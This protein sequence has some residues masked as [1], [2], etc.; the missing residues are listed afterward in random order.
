M[1]ITGL[2][3]WIP[4]W[5][6]SAL[7]FGAEYPEGDEDH[8][9]DL[10]D[11]WKQAAKDLAAL[12]PE[13][14]RVTDL[15]LKY[16]T[17]EGSTKAHEEFGKL[18]SGPASV[19]ENAAGLKELGE[20]TRGGGTEMEY[21]KIME[22]TFAGITAYAVYQLLAAW[23]WG[24]AG[25]P[26]A[27][28]AGRVAV[29]QA[30]TKGAGALAMEAGKVG[31]KNLL[32][33][34]LKQI[35]ITGVKA[36]LSGMAL[37]GGIQGYQLAAGHRDKG[38]D[39]TQNLRTGFEWGAGGLIGAPVGMGANRLFTK[40][41]LSPQLNGLF[42]GTLGGAAGGVG[43]YGAGLGWQAGTQY[44]TTGTVDWGKVDKTFH[45][46][47]L[48]A[49][50]GLGASH[51]LKGGVEQARGLAHTTEAPA[52][53]SAGSLDGTA[54]KP[55]V[56]KA[57]PLA[58][59]KS[60]AKD[61]AGEANPA[62]QQAGT[63]RER[64]QDLRTDQTQSDA[65]SG[66]KG[67]THNGKVAEVS[68][69][70][71][72]TPEP[73]RA[74][75]ESGIKP[76]ESVVA[77]SDHGVKPSDHGIKSADQ[78]GR[79]AESGVKP[80]DSG[81]RPAESG[82]K[83][84]ETG[85]KPAPGDRT[86]TE[87]KPV[88]QEP[89][90][91]ERPLAKA[92]GTEVADRGATVNA[93]HQEQP[94][95]VRREAAEA[96]RVSAPEQRGAGPDSRGAAPRPTEPTAQLVESNSR[97]AQPDPRAAELVGAEQHR[98]AA[99]NVGEFGGNSRKGI[100][101]LTQLVVQR[102]MDANLRLITPKDLSWNPERRVFVLP[103][104]R[105]VT[106]KVAATV[107]R[108]KVAEIIE[109]ANG[110]VVEIS[111]RARDE[112]VARAVAH[113]LTE[114]DLMTRDSS[115]AVDQANDRPSQFTAHLG[116]RYAELKVLRAQID[117]ATYD[118]ARAQELPGRRKDLADLLNRLQLDTEEGAQRKQWL[119]DRDPV[120]ARRLGLEGDPIVVEPPVFHQELRPGEFENEAT[121]H[122]GRLD[123]QLTGAHANEM[124]RAESMSL[125]ARMR[126]E[127]ARRIFDPIYES[128]FNDPAVR[129][130]AEA[131]K[132]QLNSAL[133]PINEALNRPG[134]TEA[135]RVREVRAGIEEFY[136]SMPQEFR[137]AFGPDR[138]E[139]M[140]EAARDIGNGRVTAEIDHATGEVRIT[141]QRPGELL[142]G[143]P[144]VGERMP[145]H[146][147]LKG[148][149]HANR[150]AAENGVSV[151]YFPVRYKELDG[152]SVLEVM[153]R[154]R[155]QHR[156]PL[157]Q[158]RFG[159]D[160]AP[161]PLRPLDEMPHTTG[162]YVLDIGTGRSA[163]AEE[164][165]PRGD[166]D[167]LM[168]LKTELTDS[169]AVPA[170]RQRKLGML[171]AGPLTDSG[172]LMFYGD[173]LLEGNFLGEGSI[174]RIYINNLSA[175]LKDPVYDMIAERLPELLAPGARIEV[176]WDMSSERK[177]G[178]RPGDRGHVTGDALL[179]AFERQGPEIR[180][181][182]RI[183]EPTGVVE[184]DYSI[185]AGRN[186]EMDPRTMAA[187]VPPRP[188]DQMVIIYDPP[189]AV[190]PE[191]EGREHRGI[192][193]DLG[194]FRGDALQGEAGKPLRMSDNDLLTEVT[195]NV[196]LVTPKGVAWNPERGVF[197]LPEQHPGAPRA[198]VTVELGEL[199]GRGGV[200]EFG[201]AEH[202]YE[203]TVSKFARGQDAA[204]AVAHVL[205]EIGMAHDPAVAIDPKAENP[206]VTTDHL[207]GR[208]AEV[209][210]VADHIDRAIFDPYAAEKLPSLRKDLADLVDTLGLHEGTPEWARFEAHEPE[211]AVRL[212]FGLGADGPLG[213]RPTFESALTPD[214]FDAATS[215]HLAELGAHL[216]EASRAD[217]L[218]A[219]SL[220]LQARMRE[221]LAR[222]VFDPIF[223]EPGSRAVR[224]AGGAGLFD[225]L[226]PINEAIN[227]P[228][229]TPGQRAAA[230]RAAIDGL[231]TAL[232]AEFWDAL[233]RD[234][235]LDRMRTA[236]DAFGAERAPATGLLD[237]A[238][239][240]VE[241]G[242]ER[243]SLPEF[244]H[245][246]DRANRGAAEHNLNVEYT[247]VVHTEV[248]GRSIVEVMPRP[249]PR[250]RLP[251]ADTVF[252]P[253]NE[254]IPLRP[255]ESVP[256]AARGGHVVDVGVGRGAFGVELTPRADRSNGGLILKTE[257]ADELVQKSQ[258]RRDMGFLD[259]GPLTEPG[260]V[261]VFADL[262]SQ[263]HLLGDGELGGVARYYVNN[264]SA[265]LEPHHY[266]PLAERLP[267]LLA[268]GGRIEL[269]WDMS[270]QEK[271][272]GQEGNRGHIRGDLLWDAIQEMDQGRAQ[273]FFEI[274]DP[275]YPV[276]R[277]YNYTID[278][279]SKNRVN[280]DDVAGFNPPRPQH[281]MVIAYEPPAE[282]GPGEPHRGTAGN[283]GEFR[284]D[285]RDS[286]QDLS[287]D[288]LAGEIRDNLR[289]ITP[290]DMAWNPE[291]GHWVLPGGG[292]VEVRVAEHPLERAVA[293]F[294]ERS[295]HS[296][297]DVLVSPRARDHDVAR[298]VAHELTEIRLDGE[299]GVVRDPVSERP[300]ALTDHL[301][302]RYA[303][304][305]VLTAH[306]D[307]ST[308]DPARA[309]QSTT[310]R[311]DLAD[312][313]DHLG[314][315]DG[316]G[317]P[318]WDLLASHAP[319][320]AHRLELGMGE[321]G[322]LGARPVFDRDLSTTGFQEA[323]AEHLGRLARELTGAYAPDLLRAESAALSGRM[324]EELSRRV[325]DPLFT[326]GDL[327]AARRTVG[328][329]ELLSALD[330][331]NDAINHPRP[332][333][334]GLHS[335][336]DQ[337][338]ASMPP[339]FHA[340]FG[341]GF[342]R[343]HT[344][345]EVLAHGPAPHAGV[346]DHAT[347]RMSLG[348]RQ[349]SFHDFLHDIDGANRGAADH[350][351]NVEYAVVLH[352]PVEGRSAV[353]VW[354]RPRPAHRLP[355][356][357]NVFDTVDQPL[358]HRMRD[359]VPAARAGGHT[360]DVGVGRGAFA[361]EMTPTADRA[362][363]GLIIK[364]ELV[365]D[366]VLRAQRRRGF[367]ILDPGPLTEAGSVM[368]F[369]DLLEHGAVLGDGTKG[370]VAR[371]YI[372]NVSAH[373]ADPYYTALAERLPRI[374][375][376]GG[377]IEVQWDMKP[378]DAGGERGNRGH[379]TGPQL[380]DA[381]Q[382]LPDDLPGQFR[383]REYTLFSAEGNKDYDYTIDTGSRNTMDAAA[384]ARFIPPRPDHRMVI[385]YEPEGRTN[386]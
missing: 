353:E 323:A 282:H 336:V 4:G 331:L 329:G 253:A 259:P 145:I 357:Q 140:H 384:M 348:D 278:A 192:A 380:W 379:I 233:G 344:A 134:L 247:A 377:R 109:R 198:E 95:P 256:A 5:I 368:V 125:N 161:I 182:F 359:S 245:A 17:G 283:L 322:L 123:N 156:L 119:I 160:H 224:R 276:G 214:A 141:G 255:L 52:T 262:L 24:S 117:A 285:A 7:N 320:L 312:L 338:R 164:L 8:L 67:D 165:T 28:G 2:W 48:A 63:Q 19:K 235:G 319:V 103:D 132:R 98:G 10:G 207:G 110:F 299:P 85:A 158:L 43:M 197:V 81:V 108:N 112:D 153:S 167:H 324:R 35:A 337:F 70:T 77:A 62:N 137:D 203:I 106:V 215:A 332:T 73:S 21:T 162:K 342:A 78:G 186:N 64:P 308:F 288:R 225:A 143:E 316:P 334:R 178:G 130:P 361:V 241:I 351:I 50:V 250:H 218:R 32:K 61:L 364:T 142:P 189:G 254:A 94:A 297:Y 309:G 313:L 328:M 360:I 127:L 279:A 89:I 104:G 30:A 227:H 371:L 84:T 335:A 176:Q 286:V 16:Y 268:P 234:G 6:L 265:K 23:P 350:G 258:R 188:S 184:Y 163:F 340:A 172:S 68:E 295:D 231:R 385:E 169:Y 34:Y 210:V 201:P 296:G 354:S 270:P 59:G 72:S 116:G 264:V 246:I 345:A 148:I 183:E 185:N 151:E 327:A 362:G 318:E 87:S 321:D 146:D 315:G 260:S 266:L 79:P 228:G 219:E 381:L 22:A 223:S 267:G 31:L 306:V 191:L 366:L 26:F 291:Q 133:N 65:T 93:A 3:E 170:Q 157:G 382:E 121:A 213:H 373:P 69:N 358:E 20:Y 244:L 293:E 33:P 302:G 280:P 375:A 128:M 149:D 111:P 370:A 252:G 90:T 100:E 311:R 289:L 37:D 91:T 1:S 341:D 14:K 126:E 237:Y 173:M 221:E 212:K 86:A 376:P 155:P 310:L 46:Q 355:I 51:G 196:A 11:A 44:A 242:G 290:K 369:G 49:G 152:S 9:F 80:G 216:P 229:Y 363:G 113:E 38:F 40:M 181:R 139:L 120:L 238:S 194:D 47:L 58:D 56:A 249:Q 217:V 287:P 147:F 251:L 175:H 374:L 206:A 303:E 15:T 66:G 25:V 96:P 226:D 92:S 154:P 232:P 333:P 54:P 36:G 211:L 372:N 317:T 349:Q 272:G 263:G 187:V 135:Q 284:G 13:L 202:G 300:A 82:G 107:L 236:A 171:D 179:E 339:E 144:R 129:G 97:A 274:Q 200:A 138:I 314:L 209:R 325:F 99:G 356:E 352:N 261:M 55:D 243:M 343:M 136:R 271:E 180:A 18:F 75:I 301:G 294:T 277:D 101:D 118:P 174:A 102:E 88:A 53:R 307:R 122:L 114:I 105:T 74:G 190:R 76:T 269:Q 208:Y 159:D 248:G 273:R 193:A 304:A 383:I 275:G 168:I 365:D 281:R 346:L 39:L 124:V 230:V 41:G 220:G 12:E 204:R 240:Q 222:R 386:G 150:A 27:L 367:G 378:E 257:L 60:T 57:D 115:L 131:F 42:S 195:D 45:V 330:P 239:R 292:T 199:P 298:A 347:G 71:R 166:R 29:G 305:E 205:T 326:D 83:P 177:V